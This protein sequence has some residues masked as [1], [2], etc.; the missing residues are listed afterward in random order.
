MVL[1]MVSYFAAFTLPWV[2]TSLGLVLEI[3]WAVKLRGNRTLSISRFFFRFLLLFP[4]LFFLFSGG[5]EYWDLMV[6]KLLVLPF[7]ASLA[8]IFYNEVLYGLQR[9]R[10]AEQRQ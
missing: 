9:S 1:A 8:L 10:K 3:I 4:V 2:F 6:K 7:I 5:R